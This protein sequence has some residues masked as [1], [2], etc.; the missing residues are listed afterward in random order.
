MLNVK[1]ILRKDQEGKKVAIENT[2]AY[3]NAWFVHELIPVPAQEEAL[4]RLDS[5]VSDSLALW[6]PEVGSELGARP[7]PDADQGRIELTS[8]APDALEYTSE[9]AA[10]GFVVFSEMWYPH[11]WKATI[12]GE[13]HPIYRVNYFLRGMN[14]PSGNHKIRFSFEPRVVKVGSSIS[15]AA[16]LF[17][18][19]LLGFA[20]VRT[21]TYKKENTD[22]TA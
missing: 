6:V 4:M 14:I 12:D 17:V 11:G 18:V 2:G 20:L 5:T 15:L 7:Y 8:Y 16:N 22:I 10:D 19:G 3:G 9:S 1:Y 13:P 21:Y